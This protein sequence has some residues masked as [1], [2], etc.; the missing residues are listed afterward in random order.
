MQKRMISSTVTKPVGRCNE[1]ADTDSSPKRNA[2]GPW[3]WWRAQRAVG[4]PRSR[5][6]SQRISG[7]R[8]SGDVNVY[9]YSR[10]MRLCIPS[11]RT[12]DPHFWQ[13]KEVHPAEPGSEVRG[14]DSSRLAKAD[15]SDRYAFW[16]EGDHT[17]LRDCVSQQVV[18]V[19]LEVVGG[20]SEGPSLECHLR[21][22]GHFP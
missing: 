10:V 18:E 19:V 11:L 6:Y 17:R 1:F 5:R 16:H 12:N 9:V 8:C 21:R 13:E 4:S 15:L 3:R 14:Y 22:R 20:L 7:C 2:N